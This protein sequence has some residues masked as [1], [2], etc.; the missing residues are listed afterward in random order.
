MSSPAPFNDIRT[1][2]NA[3]ALGVPIA[4]PN[5]PFKRPVPPA[6]W[7]SVQ[8]TSTHNAPIEL[9]GG[10]W[11]EEGVAY[12]DVHVPVGTGSDTARTLAKSVADVFRA[13]PPQPVVYCGGSIGDGEV[14]SADG[15][16]WTI[17][18]TIDWR[19]QDTT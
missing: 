19:Y 10:V 7:L 14:S 18:V 13:V 3:A 16:W 17:T 1:R 4:W 9:G 2:L 6:A 8:V 5:E 12:T 15:M 11:Q